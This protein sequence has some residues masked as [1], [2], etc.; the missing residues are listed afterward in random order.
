MTS[1]GKVFDQEKQAKDWIKNWNEK[2][3]KVGKELK[4]KLGENATFTVI[5]LYE[6]DIDLFGNNWGRGGEVIYQALGFKAPQKVVDDVFKAGYLEVSQEVL[7]KYIGDYAIVA[8]ED[9]KT[10]ASLYES[11]VWRS[12]PAVLQGHILK[13]NANAFYFNDPLSLEYELKTLENGLKAME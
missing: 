1:F 8:A 4:A 11:D 13:V 2:T 10:G 6:K 12:I 7:P 5:G 3:A 9:E